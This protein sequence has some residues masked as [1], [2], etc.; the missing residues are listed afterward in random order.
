MY[1]LRGKGTSGSICDGAKS[2]AHG[3]GSLQE[4]LLNGLKTDDLRKRPHAVKP[5][6]CEKELRK[7][8]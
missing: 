8:L 7:S 2:S 5:L 1:R 6:T 3:D 4:S